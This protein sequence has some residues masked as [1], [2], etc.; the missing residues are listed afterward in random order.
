MANL[1]GNLVDI[2]GTRLNLPEVHASEY[3]GGGNTVNTLNY[4]YATGNNPYST[5]TQSYVPTQ[6]SGPGGQSVTWRS[7][8]NPTT[9]SQSTG[10]NRGGGDGGNNNGNNNSGGSNKITSDEALKRG[11]DINTLRAM[12]LLA[13]EGGGSDA[14]RQQQESLINSQFSEYFSNLDRQI[15]LLPEEQKNLESRIGNLYTS[16]QGDITTQQNQLLADIEKGKTQSGERKAESLRELE[17]TLRNSLFAANQYLGTRGAGDSSAANMYS[18]ALS[19]QGSKNQAGIVKQF[20]QNIADL[21]QKIVNIKEAVGQQMNELTTWKNNQLL[22]VSDYINNKKNALQNMISQGRIDRDTA[23]RELNTNVYNQAQQRLA[24]IDQNATSFAQ[25]LQTWATQRAAA[26][27]DYKLQLT[28]S[29][30][31]SVPDVVQSEMNIGANYGNN[32]GNLMTGYGIYSGTKR[33][34]YGR[35]IA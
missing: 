35:L 10:G 5:R 14:Y 26:L 21:D 22:Q 1:F 33:D 12:G 29:A 28:N 11:L 32:A 25:A 17:D 30:Q 4:Q 34:Q 2:I 24:Y 13:E 20:N 15:G 7:G 31:F 19:K 8:D 16:Q 23:L 18:Y 27:N 9:T 6:T 3:L